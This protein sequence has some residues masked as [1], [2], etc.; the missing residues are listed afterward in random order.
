MSPINL[1][2]SRSGAHLFVSYTPLNAVVRHSTD[3]SQKPQSPPPCCP[4]QRRRGPNIRTSRRRRHCARTDCRF[5]T[6]GAAIAFDRLPWISAMDSTPEQLG[7]WDMADLSQLPADEFPADDP[8]ASG[9]GPVRRRKTSLRTNPLVSGPE[10]SDSSPLRLRMQPPDGVHMLCPR[11][12]TSQTFD[13][14]EIQFYDLLP[15]FPSRDSHNHE[16]R[17]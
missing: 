15:V 2:E 5:D 6:S 1:S 4:T 12:P 13:P 8:D 17:D 10:L 7:T 16:L 14:S 11:T 3:A 9:P